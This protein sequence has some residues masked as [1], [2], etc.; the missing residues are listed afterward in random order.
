MFKKSDCR[1][2]T[3]GTREGAQTRFVGRILV[4]EDVKRSPETHENRTSWKRGWISSQN[5]KS[6]ARWR[7]FVSAG[8][9]AIFGGGNFEKSP[10]KSVFGMLVLNLLL[11]AVGILCFIG[12][13]LVHLLPWWHIY[14]GHWRSIC[15][16]IWEGLGPWRPGAWRHGV[17]SA[18]RKALDVGL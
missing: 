18:T 15:A 12:R 9:R 16:R 13:T 7:E 17:G 1:E 11:S 10:C 3:F 5:W 14:V 2:L 8:L 4:S 6:L